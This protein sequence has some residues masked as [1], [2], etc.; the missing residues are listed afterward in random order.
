MTPGSMRATAAAFVLM[1]IA[2]GATAQQPAFDFALVGDMP[3]T[4]VQEIEYQRVLAALNAAD[5]ALVAHIG[6][7]QFDA[8]PYNRNP[9][10]ASMPC[11]DENYLQRLTRLT[12]ELFPAGTALPVTFTGM[13]TGNPKWGAFGAA[14]AF[15]LPSHQENFGIAVVEALACRIPVLMSNQVNIWREIVADACGYAEDDDLAGTRRLLER[16]RDTS[17]AQRAEMSA[18]ARRSF[19]RRFEINHAVDSFLQVL[20]N[21]PRVT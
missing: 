2:S 6:D 18:A 17:P 3:Y 20:E 21:P 5:L 10:M 9:A 13:L 12:T 19:A 11:V 15:I 14:E 8:T 4:K 1:A 16:W 7:F